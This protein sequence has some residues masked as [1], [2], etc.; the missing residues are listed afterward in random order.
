M[1][2]PNR[3]RPLIA[4][5]LAALTLALAHVSAPS[6]ASAGVDVGLTPALR[7]VAYDSTFTLDLQVTAAGSA[8]N[9]FAAVIE[10]DP[11]VLT[12]LP[13]SPTTAQLGCLMTGGCSGACGLTYHS[14]SAAGDSLVVYASL[15]CD[16]TS[17]TGPGSLYRLRF[18]APHVTQTTTVRLHRIRFYDSGLFVTPVTGADA[19]VN[20]TDG[21]AVG[22]RAQRPG[23][24]LSAAP[25]PAR[26]ALALTI[27]VDAPGELSLDVLDIAGR[28]VRSLGRVHAGAG[29]HTER[30]DGRGRDGE[31]LNAGVYLVRATAGT[32]V[33]QTRI[34][35]LH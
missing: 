27:E 8:F 15:L 26:G 14:F 3:F 35:L 2:A 22:P 10:Y 19:Q 30:W 25:N 33:A 1:T 17:L 29:S 24:W 7:S 11:A 32:R 16:A 34:V 6:A 18:R 31:R 5:G 23:L 21:T 4:T 13:A 20:I 12:F 9:A 28:L